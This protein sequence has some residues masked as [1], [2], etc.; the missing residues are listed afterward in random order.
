MSKIEDDEHSDYINASYIDVRRMYIFVWSQLRH[1]H[2]V[3]GLHDVEE[4]HRGA[5]AQGQHGQ[6]LLAHDMGKAL[7]RHSDDNGT[8]GIGQGKSRDAVR[9]V[10][11]SG[12]ATLLRILNK[13]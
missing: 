11:R 13:D 4:V 1:Q 10:K 5:R 3:T 7:L 6:R 12:I 9:S 8:V 2:V